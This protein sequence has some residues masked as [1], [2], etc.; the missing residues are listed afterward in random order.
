VR[1]ID[2]EARTLLLASWS[3]PQSGMAVAQH[4][5]EF[6]S[7][8]RLPTDIREAGEACQRFRA[9]GTV[10]VGAMRSNLQ[11]SVPGY[12]EDLNA[13]LVERSAVLRAFGAAL[14]TCR[15]AGELTRSCGL[16]EQFRAWQKESRVSEA[17]NRTL[18]RYRQS[19]TYQA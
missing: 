1:N 19:D 12:R 10:L 15:H 8:K 5:L 3:V 6:P 18:V 7:V 4:A 17:P 16:S 9:V 11:R 2:A 14:K 13:P